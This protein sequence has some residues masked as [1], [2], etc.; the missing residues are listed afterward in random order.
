MTNTGETI[1]SCQDPC[2]YLTFSAITG[3]KGV[4]S[5]PKL[6]ADYKNKKLDLDALVTHTLPFDKVNEA[7]DLMY[8]GKR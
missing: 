4:T 8:Q 2:V 6:A 7:F 1:P 3:W 5:V